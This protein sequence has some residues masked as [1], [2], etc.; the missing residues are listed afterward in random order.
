LLSSRP[1]APFTLRQSDLSFNLAFSLAINIKTSEGSAMVSSTQHPAGDESFLDSFS[2][3]T[4]EATHNR[5]GRQKRKANPSRNGLS[6]K[7]A[8]LRVRLP[9]MQRKR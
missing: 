8:R 3:R 6:V 9:Q 1:A 5:I 2:G 7:E 4:Q